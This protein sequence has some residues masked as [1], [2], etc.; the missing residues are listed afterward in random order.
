[1]PATQST[2]VVEFA[3]D[4]NVPAGHGLQVVDPAAGEYW[5]VV[6]GSQNDM[7]GKE[8]QPCGHFKQVVLFSNE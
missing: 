5:P 2:H 3:P 6:Q 1:M 7:P 4:V 8:D